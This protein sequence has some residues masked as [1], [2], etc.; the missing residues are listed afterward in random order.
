M[1]K[2]TGLLLATILF[3]SCSK[4]NVETPANPAVDNS[5]IAS[6]KN[7]EFSVK[8]GST[9]YASF[10]STKT[11]K[12][13]KDSELNATN[14]PEIDLV[15]VAQEGGLIFFTS[16]DETDFKVTVPGATKTLIKNFQ[17][18]FSA[19]DF[20]AMVDDSKLKA[21]TIVNDDNVIGTLQFPLTVLFQNSKGKK[22][23]IKVLSINADRLLVDIK[24]QK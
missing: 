3:V 15:F 1:K 4:D 9:A 6:Y 18:G 22:G 19:A 13:Y 11:G 8:E 2:I 23:V 5:T 20:D 21:L 10:F 16:P 7:V 17:S 14:G 24:V 12:S